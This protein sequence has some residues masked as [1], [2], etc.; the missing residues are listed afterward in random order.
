M[1]NRGLPMLGENYMFYSSG[2]TQDDDLYAVGNYQQQP[3]SLP[4]VG[5]TMMAS[6]VG[7]VKQTG[8]ARQTSDIKQNPNYYACPQCNEVAVAT[9]NCQYRD[10]QCSKGHKWYSN[11]G[12]KTS[13]SSHSH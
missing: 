6:E 7:E 11:K 8:E 12:I 13:G 5:K 4:P 3:T 10:S 1:N 9:C 2:S